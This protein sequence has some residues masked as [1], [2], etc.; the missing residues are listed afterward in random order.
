MFTQGAHY[1]GHF[2][3]HTSRSDDLKS[4][5]CLAVGQA[6]A[7]EMPDGAIDGL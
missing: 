1:V 5:R 3:V 7:A 2:G 6:P 4:A